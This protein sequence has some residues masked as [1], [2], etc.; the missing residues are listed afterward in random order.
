M[1]KEFDPEDIASDFAAR[2]ISH[3]IRLSNCYNICTYREHELDL[4]K[5]TGALVMNVCAYG[6]LWVLLAKHIRQ[7]KPFHEG[8][9]WHVFRF[10]AKALRPSDFER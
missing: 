8:F 5:G 9:I 4:A 3:L 10:L 2:E 1:R 6:D 7:R